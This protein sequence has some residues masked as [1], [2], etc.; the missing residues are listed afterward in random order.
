M[1]VVLELSVRIMGGALGLRCAD[2]RRTTRGSMTLP[3]SSS[4][5]SLLSLR[6]A[7]SPFP[8]GLLLLSLRTSSGRP[9]AAGEGAGVGARDADRVRASSASALTFTVSSEPRGEPVYGDAR[10]CCTRS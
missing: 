2:V 7:T 4:R 10:G 6:R 1:A 8:F 9:L 3:L 5:R